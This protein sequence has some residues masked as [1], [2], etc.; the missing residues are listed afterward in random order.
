MTRGTMVMADDRLLSDILEWLR[1]NIGDEHP[2]SMPWLHM[3]A[4]WS[5]RRY[6]LSSGHDLDRRNCYIVSVDDGTLAQLFR[7]TW[8]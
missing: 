8:L 3:G 2:G 7:L 1:R 6:F 4:G 5:L